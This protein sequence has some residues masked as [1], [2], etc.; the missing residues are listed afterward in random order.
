VSESK[1]SGTWLTDNDNHYAYASTDAER[2]LITPFGW[3]EHD[4][5]VPTDAFVWV[6]A[7]GSARALL[8]SGALALHRDRGWVPS[9]PPLPDGEVAPLA[10]VAEDTTGGTPAP[11]PHERKKTTETGKGDTK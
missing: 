9:I 8:A 2:D 3:V 1:K 7:D 10:G 6:G 5:P 4:G 11:V